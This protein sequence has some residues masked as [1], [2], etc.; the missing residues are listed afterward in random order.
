MCVLSPSLDS[1]LPPSIFQRVLLGQLKKLALKA[2]RV[3]NTRSLTL[4]VLQ[5]KHRASNVTDATAT[6]DTRLAHI[7]THISEKKMG[8]VV[9]AGEGEGEWHERGDVEE[10]EKAKERENARASELRSWSRTPLRMGQG[11]NN[12]R[13]DF[14]PL[15]SLNAALVVAH[16]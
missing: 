11:R 12:F 4:L 14:P 10:D 6:N 13:I 9:Q 16:Y 15:E 5:K 2:R 8:G 3:I 1:S 7:K